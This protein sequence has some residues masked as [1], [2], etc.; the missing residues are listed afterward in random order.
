MGH[1]VITSNYG[2]MA[3][4]AEKGGCLLVDP[5]NVDDARASDGA[6]LTTTTC[7]CGKLRDE[8]LGSDGGTWDGYAGQLWDFFTEEAVDERLESAL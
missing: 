1:P 5:R 4:V 8:A 2:S 6:A 3:E 7:A